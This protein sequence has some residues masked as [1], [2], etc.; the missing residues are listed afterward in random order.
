ML[1][2]S[3]DKKR[4][5]PHLKICSHDIRFVRFNN[6][7]NGKMAVLRMLSSHSPFLHFGP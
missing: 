6:V 7:T 2:Y 3:I 4:E 5:L 1:V